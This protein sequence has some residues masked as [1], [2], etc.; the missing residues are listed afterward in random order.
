[1]RHVAS[2]IGRICFLLCCLASWTLSGATVAAAGQ[3]A[4]NG[5]VLDPSGAVVRNAALVVRAEN[6]VTLTAVTDREGRFSL[7]AVPAGRVTVTA[8]SAG[9][10]AHAVETVI[11]AG[12]S[13]RLD[14]TLDIGAVT[15]SVQVVPSRVV[16]GSE[17][18]RRIPGAVE[19]LDQAV[20]ETSRAFTTSEALRKAAGVN[21]REEE[22]FG[23]RP[24]IGVRGLNPTRSS[25]VLL[26]EDGIPL[27]YAPYG[28]N[29]SYYHP[30]IERFERIELL[31]GSGQ[32][33]Y[34][35]MTVGGVINYVTPAPP[36]SSSG[37]FLASAGSRG[38]MNAHGT[39]GVTS[40]RTG[41]LFD[42]MRKQGDGA[43][44]HISSELNDVNG[45]AVTRLTDRQVFTARASYYTEDSNVT[46]SGLREDEYRANPRQNPFL[47]DSF[48]ADRYG[49]SGTHNH[50]LSDRFVAT[51]NV[52]VTGFKR[53]WWR[54]SSNSAQRPNDAADPACGGMA[55]LSTTCGNEGRLRQY[56]VW[57]VEP[58][59]RAT[60]R[61]GSVLNETDFGARLH[62]EDQERRQENGDA[63]TSRRGLLVENN[64][65]RNRAYSGFIQNRFLFGAW[66]I[67]PGLRVERVDYDR[68]NRLLGVSGRTH[69]VEAIPGVGA[70]YSPDARWTFF[71][72]VHR[73]FAPPRTEDI[74]NN[75]TGGAVDLDPERSWNYEAGLRGS[76]RPGLQVDAALFRMDYE[77]QIIPATLAGGVGSTLT[78]AGETRH[79]GFEMTGR[80]NSAPF[81]QSAQNV[82]LR[83]NYTFVPVA[84]FVGAR[85]S[86][87]PGFREIS[88]SGNRLPYAP[89]H[90]LTAGAGYSHPR[91]LDLFLE[92]VL[93]SDQFGDDLNTLDPSPD[94]Q[95]G[96][97][98]GHTM[99]N[100]AANYRLP[101][102]RAT[103]F[104]TV[105]NLMDRTVIVDRS[106]G[107][108][109]GI[110]RLVQAGVKVK[111]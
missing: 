71:A 64:E 11:E 47:N 75:T 100:A 67:T 97:V 55:N 111:F 59:V 21:V 10:A 52:Y 37:A 61:L 13:T 8:D 81:L 101:L 38:Y 44:E 30:P 42:Y 108:L 51:T 3:G 6:G 92:A 34:G 110:P 5:R 36:A 4:L 20:L 24:N 88:I 86:S 27:T 73:G 49:V 22:G 74:I 31:K 72:G 35:P 76:P 99:W 63:P 41:L 95:R 98:P 107:V 50:A 53:H 43:R 28:D 68:T 54:Q 65:R 15:E 1:M 26:L 84:T 77:N 69:L 70:S 12:R 9:F 104:V 62:V 58:R 105:K 103:L 90:L 78:N 96:L 39:W 29:A 25:K 83:A 66:S 7:S 46:Y 80:I 48:V 93:V 18:A 40:G 19:V 17:A 94:G 109:P 60:S 57:G 85:F 79:Q 14:I 33:A 32:I 16:S 89:Q 2:L 106:R 56:R 82:Y 87:V 91:G 23:L 102:Q 45:K